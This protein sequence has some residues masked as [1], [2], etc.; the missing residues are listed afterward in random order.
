MSLRS[1]PQ[2]AAGS[3]VCRQPGGHA[4]AGQGAI[5][6]RLYND[7]VLDQLVTD[8]LAANTDVRVAVARIARA[9]AALRGAPR[10]SAPQAGV[11]AGANY[12]RLPEGQRPPGAARED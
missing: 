7:P 11:S 4:R 3:F 2:T 6:W 12:G 1:T 8:A 10:R 5:W 9:R